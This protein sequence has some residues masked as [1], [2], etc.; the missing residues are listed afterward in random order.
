MHIYTQLLLFR[1]VL[2]HIVL[3]NEINN[4]LLSIVK[5]CQNLKELGHYHQSDMA[6]GGVWVMVG[7]KVTARMRLAVG[8]PLED[9][10]ELDQIR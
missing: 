4:P 7:R 6:A 9:E 5:R 8:L 3:Q 10:D 1:E 2:D